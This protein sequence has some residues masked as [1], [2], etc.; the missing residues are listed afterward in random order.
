MCIKKTCDSE[1]LIVQNSLVLCS[2]LAVRLAAVAP[3]PFRH[4]RC[5]GNLL[6]HKFLTSTQRDESPQFS[7]S[8][9]CTYVELCVCYRG[10]HA[11]W[12]GASAVDGSGCHGPLICL[13]R[14]LVSPPQAV[15][16]KRYI[17]LILCK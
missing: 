13:R 3:I 4:P 6:G 9:S 2:T 15:S 5:S 14:S 8:T 17:T 7:L 16:S 1:E 10:L 12:L 11:R